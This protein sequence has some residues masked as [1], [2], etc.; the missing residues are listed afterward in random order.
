[1]RPDEASRNPVRIE[2]AEGAFNVHADDV[3]TAETC[4]SGWSASGFLVANDNPVAAR[5]DN[6]KLD[7]PC[8]DCE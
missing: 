8:F 5:P 7:H 2:S 6:S 1:M 3:G 4:S